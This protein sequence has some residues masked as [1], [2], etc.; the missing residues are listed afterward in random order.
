M[1]DNAHP[2]PEKIELLRQMVSMC[3]LSIPVDAAAES[4]LT[5][6][7][8]DSLGLVELAMALEDA[9]QIT[10]DLDNLSADT[11]LTVLADQIL[12]G[13]HPAQ[14]P[15]EPVAAPAAPAATPPT[16]T[17]HWVRGVSFEVHLAHYTLRAL[18]PAD[19]NAD[20]VSWWN[21][22]DIQARLGAT[23]RGWTIEDARRH[24]DRFDTDHNLHLG[25]FDRA[26]GQLIG[27][28]TIN[29]KPQT[30][31]ASTNRVIGNKSYWR[32][33]LSRELSAWSIPFIFT[34][35]GMAKLSA[36]VH[37]ENASS[38]WLLE[39]LGF[40]REGVL[41]QELPGPGGS[42]LN[43]YKYGLLR[44]EW[45]Q[46]VQ[47]GHPLWPGEAASGADAKGGVA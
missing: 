17:E 18:E 29:T 45:Q 46:M 13:L 12:A 32:R 9:F 1:P 15:T 16:P 5:Q 8:L 7:G 26:R 43:V 44:D 21:D 38:I 30:G 24:V 27:F 34:G 2:L 36:S 4:T 33:G 28:Y 20:Y 47:G 40:Q 35:M 10:L 37:G 14:P 41:R 3:E 11:K 22:A 39:H 42:R 25:I 23:P 31:V 6:L 19:V